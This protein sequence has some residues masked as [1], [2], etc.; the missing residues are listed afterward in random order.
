MNKREVFVVLI[1]ILIL[2]I[3]SLVIYRNFGVENSL[4]GFV[5]AT[6]Q[7]SSATGNDTYIR[8]GSGVNYYSA[9]TM[10]VGK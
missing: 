7:P 9:T 5:I 6:F 3:F 2:V 4:T 1:S 8:E 10:K